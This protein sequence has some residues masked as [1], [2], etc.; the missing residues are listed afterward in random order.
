MPSLRWAAAEGVPEAVI[1][2]ICLLPERN[3]DD[4][5]TKLSSAELGHVIKIVGLSEVLSR[6][7]LE[8]LKARRPTRSLEPSAACGST[9]AAP[10]PDTR[11]G[12]SK[13]FGEALGC[14]Y[15]D[16]YGLSVGNH[17]WRRLLFLDSLASRLDRAMAIR[18]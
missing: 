14:L 11:Y 6:R 18:E 12:V 3:I 17:R 8:A 1:A 2:A 16:K 5:V 9:D 4:I 7:A 13:V 10:R 15:A